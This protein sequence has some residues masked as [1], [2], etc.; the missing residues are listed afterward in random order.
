MPYTKQREDWKDFPD[1]TTPIRAADMD[2]IEAGIAT[3]Q[4][5]AEAAESGT[6]TN[7]TAISNHLSDTA[8]AHDAS[9]ISIVDAGS[10]FAGSDVEAALQELGFRGA[11]VYGDATQAISATS[12]AMTLN[13]EEF[14]T[15]GFHDNVT[16]NTRLTIP[17]GL[18]G[19]YRID[20]G[21]F[22]NGAVTWLGILKNGSTALRGSYRTGLTA[23]HY[24]GH[25][26]IADL[27][28]GDYIEAFVNTAASITIGHASLPDAQ[29]FFSIEKIS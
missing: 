24:G 4:L 23:A 16:N 11:K 9:A 17:A 26:V 27:A 5:A 28:A 8:D 14:D 1:E 10:Y 21:Y 18:G 2:G 19:K 12:A 29:K 6:A 15:D 25:T 20:A 7:A 3:A 22:S 13:Q